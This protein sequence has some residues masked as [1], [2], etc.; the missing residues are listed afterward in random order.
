M[1]DKSIGLVDKLTH[2]RAMRRWAR[3]ARNAKDLKLP[4][5]RQN[6]AAAA[7]CGRI[8]IV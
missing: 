4:I 1:G 7:C 2:R 3:A 5:L 8:W 6:R